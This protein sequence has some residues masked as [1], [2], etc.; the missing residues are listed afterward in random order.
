MISD[1]REYRGAKPPKASD[2]VHPRT[3]A[4]CGLQVPAIIGKHATALDCIDQLRSALA[5]AGWVAPGN[6][7]EHPARKL[8]AATSISSGRLGLLGSEK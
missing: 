8:R 2:A 5:M 1:R 7:S 3:C 6:Q 4:R